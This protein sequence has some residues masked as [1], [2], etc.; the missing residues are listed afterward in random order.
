MCLKDSLKLYK[1][2]VEHVLL[3]EWSLE[4]TPVLKSYC[5]FFIRY[6][7]NFKGIRFQYNCF[8]LKVF[9]LHRKQNEIL[10]QRQYESFILLYKTNIKSRELNLVIWALFSPIRKWRKKFIS[11]RLIDSVECFSVNGQLIKL[12]VKYGQFC[13]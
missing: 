2:K 3:P 1:S 10:T 11:N 5:W 12:D 13:Y 7:W 6:V 9:I 4:R 8:H